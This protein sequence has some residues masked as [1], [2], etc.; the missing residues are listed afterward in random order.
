MKGGIELR[1][2]DEHPDI[3]SAARRREQDRDDFHNEHAGR[4]VGRIRRFLPEDARPD[5]SGKR[6]ERESRHVSALL[7][8]LQSDPAYAALYGNTFDKLRKAEAA[9]ALALAQA[10]SDLDQA[11]TD[12]AEALD[13][14]STL[15]DGTRVFRD[16]NG[17]VW[18]E[19]GKRVEGDAL[20]EIVWRERGVS[21]EEL[22]ARK[23][24]VDEGQRTLEA[25]LQY[26][27]E[28]LGHARNRLADE[29]NPPS[30]EELEQIQREIEDKA[31]PAVR[32]TLKL[33]DPEAARGRTASSEIEVP[34]L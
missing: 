18:T 9:T 3:V 34:K 28:V 6:A 10:T 19:D 23:K 31:P 17:D 8:L 4:D 21:Y 33:D 5:N 7:S 20:D 1:G 14:A 12:L 30:K 26:Q 15:A 27:V 13:G 2:E 22:L 32:E 25:I 24:A 11:R 29:D 16:Q